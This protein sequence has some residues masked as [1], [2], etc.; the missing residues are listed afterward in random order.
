[1][2]YIRG[3]F[4]NARFEA[5]V[6]QGARP[7]GA[8]QWYIASWDPRE[9]ELRYVFDGREIVSRGRVPIETFFRTRRMTTL[10]IKISP[11][12]PEQWTALA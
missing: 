1:M 7:A 3:R 6:Q 8:R 12:H 2:Y 11:Q 5:G 4:F 9:L 10:K